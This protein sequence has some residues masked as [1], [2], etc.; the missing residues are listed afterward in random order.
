LQSL[1]NSA[2]SVPAPTRRVKSA[3]ARSIRETE[4]GSGVTT[5]I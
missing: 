3:A 2:A 1:S 4:L 5:T